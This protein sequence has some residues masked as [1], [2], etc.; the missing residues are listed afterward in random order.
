MIDNFRQELK[1]PAGF[2][3]RGHMVAARYCA[4]NNVNLE[5]AMVWIEKSLASAKGFSN[6][7]V[8][9]LLFIGL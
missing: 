1:G 3:W 4:Q 6:L 8:K 9:A 2:G 5:E 7:A